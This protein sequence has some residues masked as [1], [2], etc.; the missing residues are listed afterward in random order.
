MHLTRV[1]A[2][3]GGLELL[4][5]R[6]KAHLSADKDGEKNAQKK[7]REERWTKRDRG[8]RDREISSPRLG[9]RFPHE[10]MER[11]GGWQQ[12][13]GKKGRILNISFWSFCVLN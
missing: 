13:R 2:H 5:H 4:L 1:S 3:D 8:D 9:C 12:E 7:G 10:R 11:E 6:L